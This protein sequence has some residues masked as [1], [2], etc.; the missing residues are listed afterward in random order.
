MNRQN[1]IKVLG[2]LALVF[3]LI[4]AAGTVLLMHR[5]ENICTPMFPI[6]KSKQVASALD[7]QSTKMASTTN[8]IMG[9]SAEGGT[10]ITFTQDGLR[11]IVEQRFYG[12][13]GMSYMRFYYYGDKIF[14][15]T[16]L[17]LMY[18]VPI[19]V[20]SSG[21][22]KIS[23]ERDYYLGNKANVCISQLNGATQPVDKDTQEMIRDYINGIL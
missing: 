1:T 22:I 6:T 20:D 13:T 8:A 3:I 11:K 14:Q 2:G 4:I 10:Q 17:N 19:S 21:T 7:E 16:K 5:G 15:I 18:A 23:E 12:E 9:R